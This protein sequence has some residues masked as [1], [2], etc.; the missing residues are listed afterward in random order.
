MYLQA[1][2]EIETARV[3]FEIHRNSHARAK[4]DL[5]IMREFIV[6]SI[7]VISP[8]FLRASKKN[9]NDLT[10]YRRCAAFVNT[11]HG[12]SVPVSRDRNLLAKIEKKG[13]YAEYSAICV[14]ASFSFYVNNT[15]KLNYKLITNS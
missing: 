11:L 10:L 4:R 2:S 1:C 14:V 6:E 12:A 13:C 5:C 9:I 3:R 15:G 7:P 8:R